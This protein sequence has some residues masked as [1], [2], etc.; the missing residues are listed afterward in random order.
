MR[1]HLLSLLPLL[2]LS[3]LN[4]LDHLLLERPAASGAAG[5]IFKDKGSVFLGRGRS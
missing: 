3:L 2:M 5:R 4:L 1:F